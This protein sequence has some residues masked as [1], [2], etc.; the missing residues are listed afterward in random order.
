[1]TYS[2][3]G[4][5]CY[6]Q[7]GMTSQIG[8]ASTSAWQA[9]IMSGA[10]GPTS[11]CADEFTSVFASIQSTCCVSASDCDHGS[12]STCNAA[13]GDLVLNFWTQCEAAVATNFGAALHDQ[14]DAF[15][16]TCE[17]ASGT[18]TPPPPPPASINP[19]Q[20]VALA[21]TEIPTISS[22]CCKNRECGVRRIGKCTV[23]VHNRLKSIKPRIPLSFR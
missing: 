5:S 8:D 16:R 9:C 3:S 1:M 14:L 11:S 20:C 17:R 7:F 15:A 2:S 22:L 13:C 10:G 23:L 18:G 19:A 21:V 6:A 4:V 12:P